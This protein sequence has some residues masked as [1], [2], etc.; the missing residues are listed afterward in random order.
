MASFEGFDRPLFKR[1]AHNDTGQS[2][3][4]QAGIVIPKDLDRYFPDLRSKIG[5]TGAT[6]DENIR[7]ALFVGKKLPEVVST[8]YQYQT[9]GG[10]RS[11]ERRITGNLS[12]FRSEASAG[13]FVLI[14]RSLS[15]PNFFRMRLIRSSDPEFAHVNASANGR[16]C[17]PSIADEKPM[18]ERTVQDALDAQAAH[19]AKPLAIFDNDALLVESRAV[20]MARSQAFQRSVTKL[21]SFRCAVCGNGLAS[22]TGLC[23]IEAAHIVPRSLKGA[24]DARNGLALCRSHHWA[25]DRGLFGVT[26]G[27]QIMIPAKVMALPQN[28]HLLPFDSRALSQPTVQRLAPSPV[29][30]EWHLKNIV[31]RHQ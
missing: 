8:R 23:E 29:A 25:F 9:W 15:D 16:K 6:A 1:L 17:G 10:T 31:I 2:S 13:D 12:A 18:P 20:R 19:E 11:P 4:H 30:L 24:D 21:Y 14:E 26:A 5:E 28:S 27:N 3:G 7:A 22:P